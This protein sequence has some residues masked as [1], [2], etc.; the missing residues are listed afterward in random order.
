MAKIKKIK[1]VRVDGTS[2]KAPRGSFDGVVNPGDTIVVPEKSVPPQFY[3]S[4][5]TTIASVGL[6]A[7]ALFR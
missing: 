2:L 1:L 7:A 5:M 4:L 6:S 3:Y